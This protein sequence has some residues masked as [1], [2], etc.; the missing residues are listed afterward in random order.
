MKIELRIMEKSL[1][2]RNPL[3]VEQVRLS[4]AA[5][6][7]QV[8]VSPLFLINLNTNIHWS[9]NQ[10]VCREYKGTNIIGYTKRQDGICKNSIHSN[11]I[12]VWQNSGLIQC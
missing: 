3:F 10:I 12:R 2:I 5:L 1:L 7:F 9:S 4:R 11:C 6:E 8:K